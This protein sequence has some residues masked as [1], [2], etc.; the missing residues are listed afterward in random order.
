M[1]LGIFQARQYQ[2]SH[3]TSYRHSLQASL[4]HN[5]LHLRPREVAG[6]KLLHSA[7]EITP[8]PDY[9]TQGFDSF[10]NPTEF[11]SIERP[12]AE[13]TVHS[14]CGVERSENRFVPLA[15][16]SIGDLVTETLQAN[17]SE[18]RL[19]LEFLSPSRYCAVDPQFESFLSAVWDP[20]CDSL[21]LLDAIN[22]HIHQSIRYE[23]SSTDVTTPSLMALE[24]RVGVCQDLANVFISCM[25]TA[26]IPARYVSGYLVTVPAP[27]E[28]KRIGADAS[29]AWVSIFLG[30]LGWIDWDPTNNI[31][32]NWDHITV[33][34]GRDYAD[35]PPIQG[36]YVGGGDTLLDVAVDVLLANDS[37]VNRSKDQE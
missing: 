5:Q 21:M 6:Q 11:F 36:V 3:R 29:H 17:T 1:S 15:G 23:P 32:A 31:R 34:W 25:R 37:P 8:E 16:F 26:G 14:S 33:A 10:G 20:K 35:V 27:G 18:S 12:H 4:C 19:A 30:Q 9:R 13:M 2:I 28:S 7:I 24:N 22:Q